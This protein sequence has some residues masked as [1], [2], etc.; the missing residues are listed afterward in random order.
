[1]TATEVPQSA[2][3]R[4]KLLDTATKLRGL[5][6][7]PADKRGDKFGEEVT[8]TIREINSWDAELRAIES[9]ERGERDAAQ[10]ARMEQMLSGGPSAATGNL[11]SGEARTLGEAITTSNEWTSWKERGGGVNDF[12]IQL[13]EE[14]RTLITSSVS[15]TPSAGLL[16]PLGQPIAPTPRQ[17]R[18]FIRDLLAQGQTN[19]AAIPYI[20]ELNPATN[21]T[22]ATAV[23]EST[24]KPE[25]VMSFVQ[26]TALVQKI[27]AW[28]PATMEILMDA[29]TLR[30]YIDNRLVYMV[31]VREEID[32]LYGLDTGAN[33]TIPGILS[34][35]D[36]ATGIQTQAEI[37]FN[38]VDDYPAA[39][40]MA[41]S[42]VELADGSPD[43]MVLHP[44]DY[45][46]MMV[47]RWGTAGGQH[48]SGSPFVGPPGTVWGLPVV[49][50]R[51]IT[52][53][54]ALVGDFGGG[55]QI[56]DRMGIEVRTSDSHSTYFTENKV[57]ILAEER[58]AVAWYR[59]DFFVNVTLT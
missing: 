14:Y 38:S 47:Q 22:A 49:R 19:L 55:G 15:D 52:T 4:E 33:P 10:I 2:E 18:L 48:D 7:T 43:G 28:I 54:T 59:P 27:A 16:R 45:W 8:E 25:A 51:S 42:K 34:A 3:L 58:V 29:P 26:K 50:T 31:K 32:L 57:A 30:S 35:S 6:E 44:T 36:A 56:F 20:R 9:I 24:A 41:I 17:R 23:P 1:M 40:G 11:G 39:L 37:E 21:E 53:L 12:R 46:T 5:R 13:G